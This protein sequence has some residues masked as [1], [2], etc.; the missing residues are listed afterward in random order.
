MRRHVESVDA[1]YPG[2]ASRRRVHETVR[3]MINEVVMDVIQ[4]SGERLAAAQPADIDAVRAQ[5]AALIGQSDAIRSD[6]VELKAYLRD[7]VYRNHRVLRMTAK[8]RRVIASLFQAFTS[9]RQL[10]PPEYCQ[11]ATLAE[12]RDGPRGSARVVADYNAG[13]TDRYAI[14]EHRRLFDPAERT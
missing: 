13:M 14:L 4:A 6:H 1:Q 2:L 8:A 5:G 12:Q 7:N 9:E 10:M 11:A 3:R